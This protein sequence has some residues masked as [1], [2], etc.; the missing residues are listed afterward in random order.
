MKWRNTFTFSSDRM[1]F[2]LT[3]EEE[4][5]GTWWT[6]MTGKGVKTKAAPKAQ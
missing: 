5:D 3:G 6:S 1:S 4:K 2:S